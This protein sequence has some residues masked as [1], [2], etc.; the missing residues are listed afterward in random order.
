MIQRQIHSIYATYKLVFVQV[1]DLKF[2]EGTV[3]FSVLFVKV[4]RPKI[5]SRTWNLLFLAQNDFI[6]IRFRQR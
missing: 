2:A 3:L 4:S 5:T 1:Y 6:D